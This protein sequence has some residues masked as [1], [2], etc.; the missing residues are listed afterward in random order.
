MNTDKLA[1]PLR[2]V[3]RIILA[4]LIVEHGTTKHLGFPEHKMNAV[5]LESL[6]GV[7]GVIE[8]LFGGLLLI[9][10]FSRFSAFVLS[11]LCA[12]A[13]WIVYAKNGFFPIVNGGELAIVYCF[14]FLY[15]AAA[16]PGSWALDG[17]TGSK[18]TSTATA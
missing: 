3:M 17:L 7:A 8:L 16:G 11:G 1:A 18:K 4:A 9:G 6:S 2:G 5:P 12:C 10:L 13:Y 14:A 15:L